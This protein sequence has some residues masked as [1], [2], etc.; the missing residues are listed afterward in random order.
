M[1][2]WP[3]RQM[4]KKHAVMVNPLPEWMDAN[5]GVFILRSGA[6]FTEAIFQ[7]AL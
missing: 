5:G 7:L 6:E 4:G 3:G 1:N 2:A